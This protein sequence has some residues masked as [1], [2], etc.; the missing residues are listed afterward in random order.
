MG[1]HFI[2]FMYSHFYIVLSALLFSFYLSLLALQSEK[3]RL[4]L[5]IASYFFSF[6]NLITMEYFYF[7]EFAR[8]IIFYQFFIW[9]CKTTPHYDHQVVSAIL[10]H[11]SWRD[12]LAHIFLHLSKRKLRLC[13]VRC[14]QRKLFLRRY[15]VYQ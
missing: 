7:L 4:P 1:Q 14:F 5:F 12:D 2:A 8:L 15:V 10:R 13:F 3:Y 11:F 6:V 9:G